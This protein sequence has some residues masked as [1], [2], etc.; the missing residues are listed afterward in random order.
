M[1]E[2]LELFEQ[3]I[4]GQIFRDTLIILFLNKT[5]VFKQKIA[6]KDLEVCFPEYDGGC[7]FDNACRFIEQ[8]FL[9][10]NKFD[11]DRLVTHFTCATQVDSVRSVM[12]DV[13][14]VV[15]NHNANRNQAL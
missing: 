4:N 13:K 9:D 5:D 6:T 11:P 15:S 8:K 7:D 2:S 14:R 1:S 3:T 10:L 12:D